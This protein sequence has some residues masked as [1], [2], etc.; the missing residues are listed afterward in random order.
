MSDKININFASKS[1][2]MKLKGIGEVNSDKIIQMRTTA[3]ITKENIGQLPG[4][5]FSAEALDEID[6]SINPTESRYL[7]DLPELHFT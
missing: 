5:K 3:P 6:F 4:L 2:L 7:G 1:E